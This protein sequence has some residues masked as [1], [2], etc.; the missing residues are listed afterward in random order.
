MAAPP[1][2]TLQL[3]KRLNQAIDTANQLTLQ[4]KRHPY[5]KGVDWW[6]EECS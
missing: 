2:D 6:N 3:L 4:P 1:P 5:L